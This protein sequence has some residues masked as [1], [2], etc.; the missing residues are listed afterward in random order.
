[1]QS[2]LYRLDLAAERLRW[3]RF[4]LEPGLPAR[5][6]ARSYHTASSYDSKL[7]VCSGRDDSSQTPFEELA[8]FDCITL[9][10]MNPLAPRT[11][12]LRRDRHVSVVTRYEGDAVLVVLG[13]T[14]LAGN[15]IATSQL[16]DLDR[17]DWMHTASLRFGGGLLQSNCGTVAVDSSNLFEDDHSSA[18]STGDEDDKIITYT[19]SDSAGCVPRPLG[20][21][22]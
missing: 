11:P 19:L 6:I 3:E 20:E 10:W 14:D 13:G 21:Q 17:L 18:S 5:S 15:E 7:F 16:F 8:I 9:R 2:T 22:R 1:M 12:S 4:D